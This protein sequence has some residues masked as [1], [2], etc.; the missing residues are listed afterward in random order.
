MFDNHNKCFLNGEGDTNLETKES[1]QVAF[2]MKSLGL[3]ATNIAL[4]FWQLINAP[5]AMQT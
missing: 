4:D 1:S 3:L 2:E 5:R